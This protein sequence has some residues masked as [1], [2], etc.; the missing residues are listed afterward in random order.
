MSNQGIVSFG[1]DPDAGLTVSDKWC[2][3]VVRLKADNTRLLIRT[4]INATSS[5]NTLP[6]ASYQAAMDTWARNGF[7]V[8][9][10]LPLN[11]DRYSINQYCP[12]DNLGYQGNPL[13]NEYINDFSFRAENF[14]Q[15]LA[16]HSLLT[17]WVY[18]EPNITPLSTGQDC[19]P[20][21]GYNGS[22][23]P[24]V[25]AAML[26]QGCTR[27]KA[28]AHA[29]GYT[30]TTYAGSLSIVPGVTDPSSVASYL[31]QM[32]TYLNQSGVGPGRSQP[33][34]W[35]AL[36]LNMENY[37]T[38]S[39]ISS[40]LSAIRETQSQ[41]G[42]G[43]PVII[44]EWGVRNRELDLNRFTESYDALKQNFPTMYF[45]QHPAYTR[46]D[47]TDYG[48]RDRTTQAGQYMLGDRYILYGA[49]QCLF[50]NP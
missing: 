6:I 19:P 22:L 48:V 27:I 21:T 9:A 37:P 29:A 35:D 1:Y 43:T 4:I 32:Y 13:L 23:S 12:N 44:G 16:P 15:N 34:P 26:F 28:G 24:Q 17:Y 3:D 2:Q 45:F 39:Y 14:A 18:N 40:L 50:H 8:A 49:I 31:K 30:A 47:S 46:D 42:D 11:F 33:Y 25:W 10:V 5:D 20:P 7:T 41:Y 36:S 38:S